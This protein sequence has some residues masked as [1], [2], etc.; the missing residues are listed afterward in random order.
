MNRLRLMT[1]I[2][3]AV[4]AFAAEAQI[5]IIPQERISEV[6]DPKHSQDSAFL[7]F[8]SRHIEAEPMNE[9]D[10]PKEYRYHF[11]NTGSKPLRI[12][13][14]VASCSCL[15]VRCDSESIAPGEEADIVALY[16]PEGHPGHFERK[17]FIYTDSDNAP[18]AVL[19][20][21]V[22]VEVGSDMSVLWPLQ[23]GGIRMRT[24]QVSYAQGRRAVERLSF[25]NL[26]GGPLKLE[27][28]TAFL[29]G[30]LTFRTEPEIVADGQEGE[31]VIAYEPSPEEERNMVK[32]ILKGLGLPPSKSSIKVTI[33]D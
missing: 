15:A 2:C 5:R 19:K 21:S 1:F 29:P 13:R 10:P 32:I 3:T 24:S 25:I 27:C 28:E 4:A 18:A 26:T 30:Y 16:D 9:D 14:T 6:T 17:I 7:Q 20:L 22:Q 33:K 12:V 31:M 23:M 8:D 11:R